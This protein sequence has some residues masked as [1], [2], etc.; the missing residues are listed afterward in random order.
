MTRIPKYDCDKCPAYCCSYPSIELTDKEI[1]RI[2]KHFGVKKEFAKKRFTKIVDGDRVLRHQKDATYGSIC[3]F[4][5]TE[6]RMCTIYEVRPQTCRDFPDD[7]HC[8]Y[9]DFL[10][11][12][13]DRQDDHEYV[14]L[15]KDE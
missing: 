5:D 2:A 14:P 15:S 10:W 4:L 9:W 6:T 7:T 12:E 1:G 3:R 13:R 8:G 11:W